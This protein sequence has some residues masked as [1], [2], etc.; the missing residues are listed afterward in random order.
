MARPRRTL[1]AL[2]SAALASAALVLLGACRR[3]APPVTSDSTIGAPAQ[4]SP[5]AP[6]A[7]TSPGWE[8]AF[9]PVLFVDGG[10]PGALGV[11]VPTI[12]DSTFADS[13]AWP[14]ASLG[15]ST[16]VELFGRAG[17]VAVVR[18][19]AGAAIPMPANDDACVNWPVVKPGDPAL[20]AARW[21]AGFVQGAATAIALD[22]IETLARGDSARL[23]ADVARM[24]SQIPNDTAVAFTGLPF[25]V[26]TAYRLRLAADTQVLAA[27]VMRRNGQEAD[28]REQHL[29]LI[30]ERRDDAAPWQLAWFTRTSGSEDAVESRELLAAVRLGPRHVPALVLWITTNDGANYSLV[31]RSGPGQWAER[32]TSA[33]TGC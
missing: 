31:L 14:A 12:T 23:A 17:R 3:D 24:A 30:A 33:Y 29:F 5:D 13:S 2:V 21:G 10:E 4:P 1:A 15:T 7:A 20:G 19:P 9:G 18:L 11:V 22:S 27:E 8:P 32:W 26:R 16:S 28:P 6:V 25:V